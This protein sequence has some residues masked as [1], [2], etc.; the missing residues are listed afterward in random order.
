[1]ACWNSGRFIY[2][3][4]ERSKAIKQELKEA[5]R[6]LTLDSNKLSKG[7]RCVSSEEFCVAGYRSFVSS[8][9]LPRGGLI[10]RSLRG[11]KE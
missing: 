3:V 5:K 1:M 8:I 4:S 6:S 2:P 9:E 7:S 11:R 10:E